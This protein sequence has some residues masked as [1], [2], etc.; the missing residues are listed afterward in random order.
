MWSEDCKLNIQ[1]I[2]VHMHW[3]QIANALTVGNFSQ[4][5]VIDLVM[6]LKLPPTHPHTRTH[7]HTHTHTHARTRSHTHTQ[8]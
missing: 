8:T 1:F 4:K 7:I 5:A 3:T 2:H 6:N